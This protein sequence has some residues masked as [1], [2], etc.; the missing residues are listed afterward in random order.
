M[1]LLYGSTLHVNVGYVNTEVRWKGLGS[2]LDIFFLKRSTKLH[3]DLEIGHE[4]ADTC[5]WPIW[6]MHPKQLT[7]EC[8]WNYM[9]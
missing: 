2:L 9:K 8:G 6:R 5:V 3:A 7:G 4:F 1:Y